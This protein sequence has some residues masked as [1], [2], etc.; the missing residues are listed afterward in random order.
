MRRFGGHQVTGFPRLSHGPVPQKGGRSG[1]EHLEGDWAAFC[2]GERTVS[3]LVDGR[4]S[5]DE[6]NN[7]GGAPLLQMREVKMQ[8]PCVRTPR[9]TPLRWSL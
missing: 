5:T 4:E 1:I 8:N 9:M 6:G 7:L 3:D 2:W